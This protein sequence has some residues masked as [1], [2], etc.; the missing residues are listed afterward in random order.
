MILQLLWKQDLSCQLCWILYKARALTKH[1]I[2]LNGCDGNSDAAVG[3]DSKDQQVSTCVIT[4]P[5][6]IL[7][8]AGRSL[9]ERIVSSSAGKTINVASYGNGQPDAPTLQDLYV[10]LRS[11]FIAPANHAIP[12]LL[13]PQAPRTIC[14]SKSF[15]LIMYWVSYRRHKITAS[16]R[17]KIAVRFHKNF[18]SLG[19]YNAINILS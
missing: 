3:A 18:F 11:P 7:I 9:D 2:N 10:F 12:I 1:V 8:V 5:T 6:S 15:K 14:K 17:L 19:C 16:C 4:P 13:Y